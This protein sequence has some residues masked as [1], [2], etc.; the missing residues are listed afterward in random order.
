MTTRTVLKD[1]PTPAAQASLST[2]WEESSDMDK[3]DAACQ[4]LRARPERLGVL[5]VRG[6]RWSDLGNPV[7][8][9]ATRSNGARE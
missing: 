3:T 9:R 8:L 6:M 5:A 2:P 7:R 4:V 1:P